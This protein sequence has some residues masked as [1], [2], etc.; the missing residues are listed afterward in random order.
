MPLFGQRVQ[1]RVFRP[2]ALCL[3]LQL[4]LARSSRVPS[5]SQLKLQ[6]GPKTGSKPGSGTWEVRGKPEGPFSCPEA[7]S[8]PRAGSAVGCDLGRMAALGR[9]APAHIHSSPGAWSQPKVLSRL[10]W[11]PLSLLGLLSPSPSPHWTPDGSP[12]SV[13]V[14]SA[15]AL[16]L[17]TACLLPLNPHHSAMMSFTIS[18][19]AP[20]FP[21][22]VITSPST[23]GDLT[24]SPQHRYASTSTLFSSLPSSLP[25]HHTPSSPPSLSHHHRRVQPLQPSP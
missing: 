22:N 11:A 1:S 5:S 25:P 21:T 23:S 13:A 17:P 9:E 4:S 6:R 19:L 16:P 24:V 15:S 12:T 8:C 7:W 2:H 20:F 3:P 14:V 10:Q 18:P